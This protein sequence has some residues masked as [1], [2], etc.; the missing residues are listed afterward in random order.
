MTPTV[1]I[2]DD[3]NFIVQLVRR[4][5]QPDRYTLLSAANG[6]EALALLEKNP[7][8]VAL[9]DLKMP[10]MGG[11]EL[12]ERMQR[13]HPDVDAIILTAHGDLTAA[14]EAMQ[15]GAVGF[16][17]KPFDPQDLRR[18]VARLARAHALAVENRELRATL[19]TP[20]ALV[21]QDPA[22]REVLRIVERVAQDDATV[23]I[24]GESGTGKE[25]VAR[26]I[27]ATGPRREQP[28]LPVDCAAISRTLIESELFGHVKGAFTGAERDRTGL[29]RLAA[30]GTVFLDEISEMPTAMQAKLLRAIQ[31]REVRPVGATQYERFDG[32]I[33][34]ATNRDLAA[35]VKSGEFREDL[36]YRINVVT[37]TLPP[38]R[39]RPSDIEPLARHFIEQLNRRK[40][41][42]RTLAPSAIQALQAHAW[43]GNVRELEN[44]L[45]CAWVFCPGP[46]IEDHHLPQS[47]RERPAVGDGARTVD[48]WIRRGFVEALRA[49]GG[50]IA[51][52]ARILGIAKTTL[53]RR[54]REF[55]MDPGQFEN[56]S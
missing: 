52:A 5:L 12:L 10:R 4:T 7:V 35:R 45:E 49:T 21:A 30:T 1:L 13:D 39:E 54:M 27:H 28:F 19:A 44:S 42:Q 11:L 24:Q 55:K 38:L 31:E 37:I 26:A 18:R 14:D 50:N 20:R 56:R 22:M 2:V 46:Q 47:V 8:D 9:V 29:L 41:V 34:C 40:G 48:D 6:E 32:R 3:E 43:P 51:R 36:F 17:T 33:I 25:L 23:L 16:V 15:R 53:Y